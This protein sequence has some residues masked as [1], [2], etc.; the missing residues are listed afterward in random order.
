MAGHVADPDHPFERE[1][2]WKVQMTVPVD[3]RTLFILDNQRRVNI[4]TGLHWEHEGK[5]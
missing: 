1:D 5:L 3:P 2:L 4:E